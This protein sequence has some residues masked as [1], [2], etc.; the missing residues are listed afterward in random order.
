MA[1]ARAK[2]LA[3]VPLLLLGACSGGLPQ[4]VKKEALIENVGAAIG[5]PA[6][7]VVLVEAGTG[8]VL[9]RSSNMTV[10]TVERQACTRP[11]TTT[12]LDLAEATAKSGETLTTGCESVSWAA[13]P[14]TRE[15]VAYAAVMYGERA[16]PGMEIA[17]RLDGAFKNS[18]L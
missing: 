8:K 7:C 14:T 17:R 3:L 6:T 2:T 9:W 12:V 4:G 18:G 11:G 1:L 13:G 16:L 15:G 5:D 10:C